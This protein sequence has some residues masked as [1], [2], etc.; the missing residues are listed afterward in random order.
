MRQLQRCWNEVSFLSLCFLITSCIWQLLTD[1]TSL[2]KIR[3]DVETWKRLFSISKHFSWGDGGRGRRSCSACVFSFCGAI[4]CEQLCVGR[5]DGEGRRVRR[6]RARLLPARASSPARPEP[7][8]AAP[9]G[10][11]AGAGGTKCACIDAPLPKGASGKL[12]I[13]G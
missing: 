1:W 4:G 5:E 8:R 7:R 2:A 9:H 3:T 12:R 10:A 6:A 11:G 13:F